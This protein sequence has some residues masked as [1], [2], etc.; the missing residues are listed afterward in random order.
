MGFS[1]C[2]SVGGGGGGGLADES[3]AEPSSSVEADAQQ[4]QQPRGTKR[5]LQDSVESRDRGS[6]SMSTETQ[7]SLDGESDD[8]VIVDRASSSLSSASSASLNK[9]MRTSTIVIDD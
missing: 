6:S 9:K 3:A 2:S 5:Q 7:E 8:C 1:P 4:Q